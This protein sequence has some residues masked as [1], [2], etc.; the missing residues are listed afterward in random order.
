MFAILDHD[1][2]DLY[3]ADG[4]NFVDAFYRLDGDGIGS[5]QTVT[6][7]QKKLYDQAILDDIEMVNRF[8]H[9]RQGADRGGP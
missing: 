6:A 4:V 1:C 7:E 9:F 3:I 5:R 2:K 8:Y